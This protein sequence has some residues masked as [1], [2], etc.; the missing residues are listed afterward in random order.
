MY[1]Q[2]KA[3]KSEKELLMYCI[4]TDALPAVKMQR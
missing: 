4:V 2:H 3:T 1:C